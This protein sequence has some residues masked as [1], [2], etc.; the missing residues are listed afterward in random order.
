VLT[1]DKISDILDQLDKDK[2]LAPIFEMKVVDH[3]AGVGNNILILLINV[4]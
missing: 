1:K 2:T 4:N 3:Q